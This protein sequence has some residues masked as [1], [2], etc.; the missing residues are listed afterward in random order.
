[1]DAEWLAGIRRDYRLAALDER[2][3]GTDP[4]SFFRH[5]FI[6]AESAGIEEVNAMTLA[7]A[8]ADGN[9]H[10]R[11]VLLKG[12]DEEG[13]TFFTNYEKC[14]GPADRFEG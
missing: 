1:M 8:D 10:A 2:I 4:I 11:I 5:W 7:T 13:F 14:Q 6:E 3:V 12:L 9:P